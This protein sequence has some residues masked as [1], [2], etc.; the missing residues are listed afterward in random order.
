MTFRL[1]QE[2]VDAILDY[3]AS[4]FRSLKTCSLVCRSWLPRSRFHLFQTCT[5]LPQNILGFSDL[6]HCPDCTFLRHA[7]TIKAT[8][9][10]WHPN[11]PIFNE[12]APSL[13]RLANVRTVEMMLSIKLYLAGAR[14]DAFFRTGFVTAFPQVTRLILTCNF[15]GT[16][17]P[18]VDTICFFSAL[19]ELHI[20]MVF[21]VLTTPSCS[22]L[23]PQMLHYL[24]L[25]GDAQGVIL[26]WLN[27]F[28][29]LSNVD[30]LT[31]RTTV[32]GPSQREDVRTALQKLGGA[33][34]HLEI[35]VTWLTGL[36]TIAPSVFDLSL[37]RNLRTMTIRDCSS[38]NSRGEFDPSPMIPFIDKL[39]APALECLVLD[40]DLRFYRTFNWEALDT[41]LCLTRFPRLRRIVI[42]DHGRGAH[43]L[44]EAGR[45][46]CPFSLFRECRSRSDTDLDSYPV[47]VHEFSR[48]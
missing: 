8:R 21:G 40:L 31:L 4:D 13:P 5:L 42:T 3:L 2:L 37:H 22:A 47:V 35:T 30:S 9:Y 43:E 44:L 45:C 39:V 7:H 36:E 11:D 12:V 34:R 46:H 28:N 6:L 33:I 25:S 1:P 48:L 41:T 29:H 19:E 20:N 23:P 17:A 18:L 15:D 27:A 24:E 26:A 14:V 32:K 16:L 10:Y 38:P